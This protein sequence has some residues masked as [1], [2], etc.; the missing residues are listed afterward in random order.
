MDEKRPFYRESTWA[1]LWVFAILWT[2]CLAGAVA[3]AYDLYQ[4]AGGDGSASA[5]GAGVTV[6][7]V[8]LFPALITALFT[9]LDV[10]VRTDRLFI[11]FGPI[12]LIRKRIAFADIESVRGLTYRPLREFGGWGIRPRRIEDGVDD[13]G[14]PGGEGDPAERQGGLRGVALPTTAGGA[15]PDGDAGRGAGS[16][17]RVALYARSSTMAKPIPP[18]AQ[19]VTMPN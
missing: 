5:L 2:A 13:P 3:A 12:H 17:A 8:L 10:E 11:A 7:F 1:P 19:T 18:A 14:Q 16:D 6:G 15:D 4:T 9:R